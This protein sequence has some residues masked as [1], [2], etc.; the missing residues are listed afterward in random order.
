MRDPSFKRYKISP[1]RYRE[2]RAIV[3]QYDERKLKIQSMISLPSGAAGTGSNGPG[4]PT[5]SAAIRIAHMQSI[6]DSIDAVCGMFE[7][8]I[9]LRKSTGYYHAC[10][11]GYI[12]SSRA[13]YRARRRFYVE[14]DKRIP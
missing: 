11:L 10:A 1:W 2:L 8:G 7:Q 4:D 3:M 9:I 12:G 14:L 6:N 5:A 13:F